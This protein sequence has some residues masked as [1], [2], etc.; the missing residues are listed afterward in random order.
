[1]VDW[2]DCGHALCGLGPDYGNAYWAPEVARDGGVYYMY[3]SVGHGHTRHQLRV[4]TSECP[5][6]PYVDTGN[7]LLDPEACPFA[8]DGHPFC[9]VDGQWY[10]FYARDF[11]DCDDGMLAGTG[12]VVD[13]LV[14]MVR[15]AG[16]ARVV[17][18]AKHEWQ[19]FASG[20]SMYGGIY[21][22]HTL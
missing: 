2:E 1:M 4:A 6:G 7:P 10:L 9:D 22:W 11:L 12:V 3:Y 5:A 17:A 21:D 13:R 16:D 14:D 20:R 15:L 8:I 19:R 18:R